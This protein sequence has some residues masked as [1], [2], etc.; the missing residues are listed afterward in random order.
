MEES[1]KEDFFCFGQYFCDLSSLSFF[2]GF[3]SFFDYYF[4]IR[5][6]NDMT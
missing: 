1:Q 2:F 5:N 6:G 3:D 4:S